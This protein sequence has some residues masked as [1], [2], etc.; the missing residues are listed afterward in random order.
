LIFLLDDVHSTRKAAAAA[1]A[2]FGVVVAVAVSAGRSRSRAAAD[3]DDDNGDVDELSMESTRRH[4]GET[5]KFPAG[6]LLTSSREP[7]RPLRVPRSNATLLNIP[8]AHRI[9]QQDVATATETHGSRTDR[10]RRQGRRCWCRLSSGSGIDG[11]VGHTDRHAV[12]NV[13]IVR[14]FRR[15]NDGGIFSFLRTAFPSEGSQY[16]VWLMAPTTRAHGC[17]IFPLRGSDFRTC[18]PRHR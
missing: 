14:R 9:T 7:L 17:G 5:T 15:G 16:G 13:V 4:S 11:I 6:S 2:L 1:L 18:P 3:D 10:S 12:V 8:H